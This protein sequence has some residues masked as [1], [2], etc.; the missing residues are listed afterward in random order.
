MAGEELGR[1]VVPIV[2][3]R[4]QDLACPISHQSARRTLEDG[5]QAESGGVDHQKEGNG[6][7]YTVLRIQNRSV[8]LHPRIF[9]HLINPQGALSA[10]HGAMRRNGGA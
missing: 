9:R 2:A 7:L 4:G 6:N 10:L 1:E 3:A 8:S 5:R